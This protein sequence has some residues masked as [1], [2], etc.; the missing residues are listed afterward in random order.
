MSNLIDKSNAELRALKSQSESM[1]ISLVEVLKI[2]QDMQDVIHRLMSPDD[3]LE[4]FSQIS[5]ENPDLA[6]VTL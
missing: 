5:V 2:R 1:L 6:R 3:V 4:T